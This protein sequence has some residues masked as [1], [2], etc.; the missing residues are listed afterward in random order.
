VERWPTPDGDFL[1]LH[2]LQATPGS[3]RLLLLHGLEGTQ[4]SHYV[5][6]FY[7]EAR[8]RGWHCDLLLFRGCGSEPNRAPRFYHS[9]ETTDL[10]F[11][12]SS[13]TSDNPDQPLFIAGVSLGGNVLLKWLG[14]RGPDVPRQLAGA[15]AVSV[16]YDLE[17][18]SRHI[19]TGFRR[20]YDRH[21]LRTLRRKAMEKL[22]RYP[23]LFDLNALNAARSIYQFDEAITAPVHGFADAHDY[24]SRSSAISW[25]HRI[26]VPTLLLSA[27][28][29]PFLPDGVL[30]EVR[31]IATVNECITVEFPAHGGHVG[32]VGGR[33][34]WRPVYYGEWRTCEFLAALV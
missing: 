12:V 22:G 7:A 2:R 15:A 24:Y 5:H 16:P 17:R 14:E 11:V 32:F 6:G 1:E 25:I 20:I 9:G 4:H 30:D 27:M 19:A 31:R 3:P 18:G 33:W 23:G 28:D 13:L 26:R 29:D 34:P 8:R 10:A 21:F